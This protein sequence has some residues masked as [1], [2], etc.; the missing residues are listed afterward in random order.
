MKTPRES[1][2]LVADS[3]DE[4]CFGTIS[5]NTVQR[6]RRKQRR[7]VFLLVLCLRA[8]SQLLC[9]YQSI[10]VEEQAT[11]SISG[12]SSVLSGNF[13]YRSVA[14]HVDV[15]TVQVANQP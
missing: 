3:E 8:Y 6:V 9:H 14:R 2:L 4:S 13:Q 5:L 12:R 10:L 7:Q 15:Y 11:T 1:S